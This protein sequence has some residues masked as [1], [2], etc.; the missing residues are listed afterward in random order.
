MP[1]GDRV[2]QAEPPSVLLNLKHLF[3]TL[4]TVILLVLCTILWS[5]AADIFAFAAARQLGSSTVPE[6]TIIPRL[7][8]LPVIDGYD[9]RFARFYGVEGPSISNVG[10][11]AQDDQGFIWF[12]TPNGLNRFD[13]FTFE[14]FT[15]DREN[16]KS[17]G[18][19]YVHAL[20][21]DR[22]STLWAGSNQYLNRFDSQTET[23]S[24]FP[25]P[26][27]YHIS[28]DDSATLWLS[29]PTGLYALDPSTEGIRRFSHDPSDPASLE[30]N[31][32]KST[33]EDNKGTF[34]V[35]TSEGLDSFDRGT[36]KVRLHIP[37]H[38]ASFPSL[39]TRIASEFSGSIMFPGILWRCSTARQT[40]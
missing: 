13:G 12:G 7:T 40:L 5:D 39:S 36:G 10:P 11:F 4:Q 1:V 28:Q 30:S 22:D 6:A 35:A 34:W 20:F 15:Q 9:V 25:V 32:I 21:K 8:R 19:S 18:G 37:I 33:G 29:T 27:V 16:P 3:P 24:R 23:F 2:P 17:I 31:D 26:A 14:V 38:E